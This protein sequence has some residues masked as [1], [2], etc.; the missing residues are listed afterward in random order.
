[1]NTHAPLLLTMILCGS[2]ACFNLPEFAD[3]SVIDRPRVL[4]VIAN[5]PEVTQ[6]SG[7]TLDTLIV[8]AEEADVSVRWFACAM[9]SSS[10]GGGGGAQYGEN[11]GDQGCAGNA[12]ELGT[13]PSVSVPP[14][15]TQLL[16]SNDDLVRATLGALLPSLELDDVRQSVGIPFSVEADI[17]AGGKH[18][19]AIKRILV[20]D[21]DT[22]HGNP[23]PPHFQFGERVVRGVGAP[24]AFSCSPDD[25]DGAGPL[26]VTAGQHVVLSP[27]VDGASEEGVPVEPWLESYTVLD[28]R[29]ELG[30]RQERAFYAWFA[31]DGSLDRSNTRA[32][33]RDNEWTAPDEPGCVL[34]WLV[35][36]DGHGGESACE[37]EVIVG[38]AATCESDSQ[39]G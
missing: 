39:G 4:S 26:R 10:I 20:R 18:L 1:M 32:P 27:V 31:T 25:L 33:T 13:G 14:A 16:F 9:F 24:A 15:L 8:G 36:R 30:E 11:Q 29:G 19:R 22:P 6:G 35:V 28:A 34:M 12:M 7:V 5:P 17:Q 21:T 3:S 2:S 38:D 23:P 37:Y